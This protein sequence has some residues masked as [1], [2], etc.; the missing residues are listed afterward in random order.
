MGPGVFVLP[1]AA[2]TGF[3]AAV[4]GDAC[5]ARPPSIAAPQSRPSTEVGL[6]GALGGGGRGAAGGA[7]A[8]A[9]CRAAPGTM[10]NGFAAAA[11]AGA[12]A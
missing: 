7:V 1:I 10:R 5:H 6:G 2:L 11:G 8:A 9:G 4:G 3:G 12:D